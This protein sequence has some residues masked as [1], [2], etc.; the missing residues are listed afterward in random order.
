M[1]GERERAHK[2]WFCQNLHHIQRHQWLLVPWKCGKHF[3]TWARSTQMMSAKKL[4][5]HQAPLHDSAQKKTK[6]YYWSV[7]SKKGECSSIS[8]KIAGRCYQRNRTF[9]DRLGIEE[10]LTNIKLWDLPI[11]LL[12]FFQMI[13]FVYVIFPCTDPDWDRTVTIQKRIF[14]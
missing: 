13:C 2:H 11:N 3:L 6:T 8:A 9:P 10:D 14:S 1:W 7:L 12:Y 5:Y 4:S